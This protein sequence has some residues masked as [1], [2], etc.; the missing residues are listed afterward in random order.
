[1]LSL[2]PPFPLWYA[3]HPFSP[4][5]AHTHGEK[6]VGDEAPETPFVT[7]LMHVINIIPYKGAN[8]EV[9]ATHCKVFNQTCS[10]LSDA[11]Q[12]VDNAYNIIK[13]SIK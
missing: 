9:Q 2:H 4:V 6:G 10:S 13:R 7:T 1:M 5:Q 3:P 8:I 11:K 12:V